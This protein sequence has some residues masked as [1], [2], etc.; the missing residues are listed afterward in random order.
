MSFGSFLKLYFVSI[1][2]LWVSFFSFSMNFK[3]VYM[4]RE[5]PMWQYVK[6][7]INTENHVN[8]YNLVFIGD[9]RAKAGLKPD[10]I[11]NF[12]FK[13]VNLSVGGGTPV[14]GYYTLK[15]YLK[16]HKP[17]KYLILSYAPYHLSVMNS[18]W[19]RTVKFNFLPV[20]ELNEIVSLSRDIEGCSG[21]VGCRDEVLDYQIYA[22]K[23]FREVLSGIKN[24]SWSLN[25]K[26]HS[27]AV[28]SRGHGLFGTQGISRGNNREGRSKFKFKL[29][30][31]LDLFFNK[32]V[33]LARDSDIKVFYYTMPFNQSSFKNAKPETIVNYDNYINGK[34]ARL[35]I[36]CLNKLHYLPD[37]EFGDPSHVFNGIEKV[38]LDAT[39][40]LIKSL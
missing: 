24:F 14:E 29:S 26:I 23:Y 4:N 35:E 31:T 6:D 39:Q 22:H 11:D 21:V 28:S 13:S 12:E 9:S 3:S 40:R 19:Q 7:V 18:F 5:Y 25:A 17:P 1:S 8:Y 34:C 38:S 33:K 10:L 2:A 20:D 32:I 27:Y 36:Y 37:S 16:N 30:P 15:R